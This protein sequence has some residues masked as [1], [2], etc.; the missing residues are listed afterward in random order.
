VD[1]GKTYP[2]PIID[3]RMDRKRALKPWAKVRAA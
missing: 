2:K 1:L 3:H